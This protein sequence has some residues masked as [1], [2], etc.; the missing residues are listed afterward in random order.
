MTALRYRDEQE[1]G[2]NEIE[3]IAD[4]ETGQQNGPQV[5]CC[6][7]GKPCSIYS[8]VCEDCAKEIGENDE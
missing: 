5:V 6:V 3:Q 4:D 1:K 2:M 8:P 7:C